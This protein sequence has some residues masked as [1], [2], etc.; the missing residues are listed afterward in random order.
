MNS[1]VIEVEAETLEDAIDKGLKRLGKDQ[2]DTEIEILRDPDTDLLETGVQ[3]AKIR[4][5]APGIDLLDA[6]HKILRTL[7]KKMGLTDFSVSVY[8]KDE[9]HC[10]DIESDDDLQ[11]IIGRYGETLNALQHLGE[12]MLNRIAENPVDVVVDAD[13]YRERRR[14]DLIELARSVS[15]QALSENREIELDP[16]IGSDRKIIH[17]SVQDLDGVKTRSIG[18]ETNRRVV[19]LP[20]GLS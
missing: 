12:R 3:P 18:E 17:E 7:L 5:S 6:L 9:F 11:F 1:N 8:I 15:S 19:I 20:K 16:M 2:A 10:A 13:E 14:R 4:M